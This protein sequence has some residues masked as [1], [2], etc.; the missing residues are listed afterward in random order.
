MNQSATISEYQ[1]IKQIVQ[2]LTANE[3]IHDEH[4][5]KI[6]PEVYHYGL[7]GESVQS[8]AEH[9]EKNRHRIATWMQAIDTARASLE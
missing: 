3:H 2:T 1:Q 6:F 8:L 5:S 4:L 7:Q 9:I